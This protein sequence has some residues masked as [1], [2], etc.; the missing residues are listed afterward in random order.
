MGNNFDNFDFGEYLYRFGLNNPNCSFCSS[1]TRSCR[2]IY[3]SSVL[4]FIWIDFDFAMNFFR[5]K[6]QYMSGNYY[7]FMKIQ[8]S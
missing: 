7:D 5:F 6:F 2:Y 4:L 3:C 8:Q 1:L